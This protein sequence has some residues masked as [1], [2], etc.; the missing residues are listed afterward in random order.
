MGGIETDLNGKI[1][2]I[3]NLYAVG[4]VASTR[5]HGANRLASNS[6][7]E[8]LVFSRRAVSDILRRDVY[9][10]LKEFPSEEEPL[11]KPVDKELKN[12]LRHLMWEAAGITREKEKL[13]E[14]LE[15]IEKM[16][17]RDIGKL[18]RLRLNTSRNIVRSAIYREEPLGAHYII[19]KGNR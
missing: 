3:E 7:L 5:V 18:L 13:E 17:K 11:W 9:F 2:G 4:E 15:K 6:L 8:G 10:Q 12:E 16:L 1:P 14:A 19:H